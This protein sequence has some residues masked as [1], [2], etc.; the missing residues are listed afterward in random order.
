MYILNKPRR[1]GFYKV[2]DYTRPVVIFINGIIL[3]YQ[4]LLLEKPITT[5]KNREKEKGIGCRVFFFFAVVFKTSC[6]RQ[7]WCY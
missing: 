4:R 2:V 6:C 3:V 1:Q 5:K 7:C